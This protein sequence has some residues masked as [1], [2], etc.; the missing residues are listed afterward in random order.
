MRIIFLG[1]S[2]T[3]AGR[4]R[5]DLEKQ[6]ALG[7]GYVRIIG[8]RLLGEAPDKYTIFNMG[9]SGNRIVDLYARIKNDVWNREPDLISILIGINDIWH[10]I[11]YKNG[12]DIERYEKVYR[13]IIEDTKKRF[14][15]ARFV[16]C[17]PFVVEGSS[18]CA[19]EEMPD[20]YERFCEV[21]KYASVVKKLSEEYGLY[22]LPLQK[23]F[24]EATARLGVEYY[25]PDGVHPNIGGSS[26]VAT[27]WVSLFRE[28]IEKDI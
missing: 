12:V 23:K 27:E 18:T 14:P 13:M 28:K 15:K 9:I 8:D 24:D 1:D 7:A 17:E 20:R 16:L 3:D 21:Y 4:N 10:E 22:F 26:L 19:T 11:T 25:A 6:Y 2:I 5:N